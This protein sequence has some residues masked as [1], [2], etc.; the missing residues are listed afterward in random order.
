MTWPSANQTAIISIKTSSPRASR[1]FSGR[2]LSTVVVRVLDNGCFSDV[3]GAGDDSSDELSAAFVTVSL[4][5]PKRFQ[6]R[7]LVFQRID[8]T[9]KA[10]TAPK[11]LT[12]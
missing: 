9:F 5:P 12:S 6:A 11:P 2:I 1:S 7:H 8:D 10:L 4:L 3:N